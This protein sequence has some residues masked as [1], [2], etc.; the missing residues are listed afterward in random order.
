MIYLITHGKRYFEANPRMNTE[1]LAQISKLRNLL[2]ESISLV[3]VGTGK[4]FQQIYTI[5]QSK[6]ADVPVKFSLFCGGAD[7]LGNKGAHI[8]FADARFTSC[9]NYI[10]LGDTTAFDAWKFI[11]QLPDNTLL[12][13]DG[14]LMLALGLKNITGKGQLFQLN[15]QEKSGKKIS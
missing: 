8:I 6:L 7:S 2:P 13:A 3:V 11:A 5:L 1:G 14:E 15:P 4:R 10:G 12:C 9:E